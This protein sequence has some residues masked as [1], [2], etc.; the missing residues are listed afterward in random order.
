MPTIVARV[1]YVINRHIL[2]AHTEKHSKQINERFEMGRAI[3]YK[4][5]PSW[6]LDTHTHTVAIK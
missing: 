4:M 6:T 3:K 5:I 1:H 2:F